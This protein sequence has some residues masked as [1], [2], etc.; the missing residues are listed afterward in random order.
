MNNIQDKLNSFATQSG[1][2]PDKDVFIENL[3][4]RMEKR[5]KSE[6]PAKMFKRPAGVFWGGTKH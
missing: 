1:A 4:N 2:V 3:H 6:N 5:E